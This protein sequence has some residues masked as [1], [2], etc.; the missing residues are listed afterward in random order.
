MKVTPRR[1]KTSCAAT[2][3]RRSG[4]SGWPLAPVL[5]G[6]HACCGHS[7]H[8]TAHTTPARERE[9]AKAAAVRADAPPGPVVL[10]I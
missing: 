7:K 6:D 8:T 2:P 3:P 9:A 4:R 1:S 5:S 10:L